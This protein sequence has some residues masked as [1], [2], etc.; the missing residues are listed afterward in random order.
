MLNSYLHM[1]FLNEGAQ[2]WPQN[3]RECSLSEIPN[4]SCLCIQWTVVIGFPALPVEE[5]ELPIDRYITLKITLYLLPCLQSEVKEP[6]RNRYLILK[7]IEFREMNS[8][9]L[10][11]RT[12]NRIGWRYSSSSHFELYLFSIFSY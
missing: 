8:S 6:A 9:L 5:S 10:L 12:Q 3:H 11:V 7:E 4:V 1:F 2:I